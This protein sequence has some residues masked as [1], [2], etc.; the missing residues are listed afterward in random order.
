ML[1]EQ[2]AYLD[3]SPRLMQGDFSEVFLFGFEP[4]S[5]VVLERRLR[6]SVRRHWWCRRWVPLRTREI[7]RY[8]TIGP[9]LRPRLRSTVIFL[10]RTLTLSGQ[11]LYLGCINTAQSAP[12]LEV[13]LRPHRLLFDCKTRQYL[14]T[15]TTLYHRND[16]TD[17]N[18]VSRLKD[19]VKQNTQQRFPNVLVLRRYQ[20][21]R[22]P[23]PITPGKLSPAQCRPHPALPASQRL[24]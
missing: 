9:S 15:W 12:R 23:P 2:R 24:L 1:I 21:A 20:R 11:R 17:A 19:K 7:A 10:L 3:P 13:Y 5:K 22:R 6:L 4:R 14:F 8:R 16:D 18:T